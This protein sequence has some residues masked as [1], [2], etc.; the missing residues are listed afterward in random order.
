MRGRACRGGTPGRCRVA[1]RRPRS[2]LLKLD[3]RRHPAGGRSPTAAPS[4]TRAARRT[5]RARPSATAA[6]R[7]RPARRS[8]AASPRPAG[9]ATRRAPTRALSAPRVRRA[10]RNV[11]STTRSRAPTPSPAATPSSLTSGATEPYGGCL[12][13]HST[14]LGSS[15]PGDSPHHDG[16]DSS[17]PSCTDCHNGVYARARQ[18]HD[19]ADCEGC[20]V[21]MNLPPRPAACTTCHAAATF[22]GQD[23]R[24]CHASA[25]HDT[26]P[27]AGSCTSCHTGYQKHAGEASCTSCHTN[28]PAFHH[29]TAAPAV[30]GCR[31]C[32]AMKHAGAK[33]SGSRCADCHKGKAPAAK[34]RAQHSTSVTKKYVCGG[35]HT[36]KLHAKSEGASTTCRTCHKGKYHAG[37]SRP[38]NSVCTSS[39]HRT[40]SRHAVGFRCVTCH[41]RAIHDPTP[42]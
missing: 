30:K 1:L 36:K 2:R 35:C 42:G 17:P 4:A 23:C 9:R 22:G 38:G 16:V 11:T 18:S 21:G 15:T 25:I 26:T 37:Q 41:R 29:G 8:T 28:A 5:P 3:P 7:R 40:A 6:S 33:V 32:H 34:P 27:N 20:H 24:S 13:C 10:A 12:T 19:G 31:S 14:S 39:C